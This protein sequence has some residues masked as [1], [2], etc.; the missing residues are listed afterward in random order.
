VNSASDITSANKKNLK[1]KEV[2]IMT[3]KNAAKKFE[4]LNLQD[5][6]KIYGKL[7]NDISQNIPLPSPIFLSEVM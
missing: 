5:L 3:E 6:A 1:I 4:V 7:G 2:S